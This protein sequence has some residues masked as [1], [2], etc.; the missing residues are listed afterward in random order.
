MQIKRN[1][2]ATLVARPSFEF[3]PY[4]DEFVVQTIV[5]GYLAIQFGFV[6]LERNGSKP[7]DQLRNVEIF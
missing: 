7:F 4:Y 2:R 3:F 1:E 6:L 5:F